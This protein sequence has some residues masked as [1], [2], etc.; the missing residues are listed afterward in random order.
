[1]TLTA[2]TRLGP[3]EIVA[4]LGS[5]GMGEVYRARDVRLGRE[6][7]VKVL[8]AGLS[9]DKEKL[10][11]FAQE[12]RSASALS[13]P[14]IVTIFEVGQ[15][16][17][18]PFIAMELIEGQT[19]RAILQA[20]PVSF[21]KTLSFGH[22]VA[23]GLAKAHLAG[24]VHRDLKPENVMVTGDGYAKI[25]DFGLAK[26]VGPLAGSG[27]AE[28]LSMTATGF[29]LGTAGYMS[30]E[31]ASGKSVDFRS[32][33]FSLGLILYEMAT[34]R[35]AF[36]RSTAVQ[37]LSAI[38]Q[39]DPEPIDRINPR[40][41]L[42][43]R[44]IVDRC[45]AK[46]PEERYA[47]TRDL[48]RDLQNLRDSGPSAADASEV[49]PKAHADPSQKTER[50]S[51]SAA[52]PAEVPA[53]RGVT[54]KSI[55]L[56]LS[57]LAGLAVFGAGLGAGFWVR[58]LVSDP[59][60]PRWGGDLLLAGSIRVFAPR[61][62]PDSQTLAFVTV[63]GGISQVA[64]MKPGTGDWVVLTRQKALG[65]VDRVDW[66]RD[67]SRIYFDRIGDVSRSIYSIPILGGEER[68]VLD[69]AQGP[70][71]L[72]DG[73]LLVVR[74]DANRN[75]QIHRYWPETGR[76]SPVGPAIVRESTGLGLRAFAD[77]KTA[78]FFGKP[79]TG[80]SAR[81]PHY[82]YLLDLATGRL[83]R[84]APDLPLSPPVTLT[85]D[86]TAVLADVVVG[87]LHR[88]AR[89]S[90][91]GNDLLTLMTLPSRPWY[92]NAGS[93]GSLYVEFLDN[94]AELLRFAASGG[95]PERLSSVGRNY[96]MHPIQ[97]P[98]GRVLLP[99]FT[100]GRRRLL[101]ASPG[102][103][104]RPFLESTEQSSPPVALVGKD[105]LALVGGGF[106]AASPPILVLASA[107]DGRILRRFEQTKGTGCTGL[108]VSPDEKTLYS[109]ESGWISAIDV[110]T[111]A[112]R[113]LRPG[114]GVAADPSGSTLVVQL[115]DKTGVHLVRW[116]L[117]GGAEV[118]I[119]FPPDVRLSTSPIAGNAV[120]RDGR[121]VVSIL[122]R[123]GVFSGPA[124]LDPAS[125]TLAKVPV[126]YEGDILPS[127]WASD[128]SLLGMGVGLKSDLWRFRRIAAE[129]T[130]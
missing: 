64:I 94:P 38:I 130:K 24:I 84:F 74:I 28:A 107:A 39:D 106:S 49:L 114:N 40:I 101:V 58:S 63:V 12:A 99:S 124:I 97:L 65:S 82:A 100:S 32:D 34:G 108:S 6:V 126:Q 119:A 73:T 30:P 80:D 9:T 1:M 26:L 17:A 20:G 69:D 79:A 72:P 35:R 88:I 19:L 93:D 117:S 21:K 123:D 8:P 127:S 45:L 87:D 13:H 59:P 70:E 56:A 129:E 27:S 52:V 31:Q 50:M 44:W 41:P 71:V 10:V 43:F 75:F 110:A 104:L 102:E 16:G 15:A 112:V 66:S 46:D 14:N 36:S 91:G 98:D 109:V 95:V 121:I 125:G 3:F 81:A 54:R 33:Q 47:S 122:A 76:L 60:A 25:L 128:G 105:R 90:R 120:G 53:K 118:P 57:L 18:L 116:P 86:R 111:G 89:V 23:D 113:R 22:Q 96:F 37:T 4:L 29:V 7:A 92:V 42:P 48:V 61:T 115:N 51:S 5:G 78:I 67:G 77:G 83:Q 85:G 62:S 11:R 68:L 55:S 103:A 2:G